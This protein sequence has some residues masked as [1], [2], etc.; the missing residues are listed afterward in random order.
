MAHAGTPLWRTGRERKALSSLSRQKSAFSVQPGY[1]QVLK[2]SLQ[3]VR[4]E[5]L[6]EDFETIAAPI[7]SQS[8]S[9]SL[10]HWLFGLSIPRSLDTGNGRS[11]I[12]VPAV[13]QGFPSSYS[14]RPV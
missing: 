8:F 10:A 2:F 6:R 3:S 4:Q 13:V 7:L 14:K 9:P 12:G 11:C 5:Y 1:C